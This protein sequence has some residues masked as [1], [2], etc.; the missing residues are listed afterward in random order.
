[1][2][3]NPVNITIFAPIA[4]LRSRQQTC[5]FVL[6]YLCGEF[7]HKT[8][9]THHC[10]FASVLLT[11][12]TTTTRTRTTT[13]KKTIKKDK[14]KEK[15]VSVLMN[16]MVL[17][18]EKSN[19][20]KRCFPRQQFPPLQQSTA[21]CTAPIATTSTLQAFFM[22]SPLPF[23]STSTYLFLLLSLSSHLVEPHHR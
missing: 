15:N 18:I 1:M 2:S 19:G 13:M 16:V 7:S 11:T 5:W 23:Y 12:T 20:T 17:F 9:R 3:K 4:I 14:K 10:K 22:A 6:P 21:A 8:I